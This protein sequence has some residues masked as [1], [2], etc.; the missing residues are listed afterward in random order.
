MLE[1]NR[2]FKLSTLANIKSQQEPVLR[3]LAGP[4]LTFAA[5]GRNPLVKC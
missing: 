3:R 2:E 1:H 5:S 4:V